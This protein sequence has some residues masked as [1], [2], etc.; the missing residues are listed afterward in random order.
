MKMKKAEEAENP[1]VKIHQTKKENTHLT[2]TTKM[3]LHKA[4]PLVRTRAPHLVVVNP[5][6][7]EV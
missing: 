5:A 7:T 3:I 1:K 2:H 6:T 4:T